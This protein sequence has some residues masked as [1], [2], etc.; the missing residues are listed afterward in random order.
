MKQLLSI[1]GLA[2]AFTAGAQ[3]Y[4]GAHSSN[5]DPLKSQ[6]FNPA[7]T[8]TSLT[9]WSVNL[10]GFDAHAAQDYLKLTG[11]LR[12]FGDFDQ[13]ENIE[14]NLNGEDKTGNVTLDAQF[15]SFMVNTKRAGAFSFYTRTRVLVEADNISEEFLTSV[16]NDANNIYNWASSIQ[17]DEFSFNAHAFAEFA[18][19]YSR[20]VWKN[21][22]F[23]VS[24]GGTIKLL[25]PVF[26]GKVE[27][28]VDISINE[29][30]ETANFGNTYVSAISS[31]VL[32]AIDDDGVWKYKAIT[33]FGMDLGATFEWK[34]GFGQTKVVGKNK[35]KVRIQPDYFIKAGVGFV[36]IG[37]VK[38][39]HSMYS[40]AFT[41][42]GSTVSLNDITQED[43]SFIDFDEVL[44]AL[45]SYE[46]FSGSYKTKLPTAMSL[47]ADVKLT[48]GIYINA[49]ALVNIGSFRSDEP[50][51]RAQNIYSL[52]PRFELPAVGIYMPMAYNQ[53]NGFEMGAAIRAGQFVVGSS[54]IFS[55]LWN[56][57]ATSIDL[58]LAIAFGA[59]DKSKKREMQE[60]LNEGDVQQEQLIDEPAPAKDKKEKTDKKDKKKDQDNE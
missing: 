41:A 19:G 6:L 42:D 4:T 10:I 56:R 34:T 7:L 17:D 57:E 47:F 31:D 14:E 50:K 55:Y 25:S 60:L 49:S 16:Y 30:A 11:K 24:A 45:G 13:D 9:K 20:Y 18:L 2:L 48:R 12:D 52:T 37:K 26:S 54:N 32:N 22:R 8:A 58:Q 40:R 51:A 43:S 39:R 3:P 53:V 46:E 23:A 44:N 15:P 27:G 5:Y 35:D 21:D 38:Y 59:V 36:D 28:G 1:L 29:A 33:G